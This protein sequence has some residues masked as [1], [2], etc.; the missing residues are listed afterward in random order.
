MDVKLGVNLRRH[1]IR[2]KIKWRGIS[3]IYAGSRTSSKVEKP[4]Q[5]CGPLAHERRYSGVQ[6]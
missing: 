5:C 1:G 2:A 6:E 3:K 4:T